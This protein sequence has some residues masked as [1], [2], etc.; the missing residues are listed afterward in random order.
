VLAPQLDRP[1]GAPELTT[2]ALLGELRIG[3][4]ILRLR[5][6]VPDLPTA[7]RAAVEAL[8]DTLSHHFAARRRSVPPA[9]SGLR[10]R[11][12]AAMAE[13]AAAMPAPGAQTAWLMLAGVQRSLFGTTEWLGGAEAADA[14]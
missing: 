2:E 13:A 6:T 8:L 3:L 4:N 12:M 11:G 14:R 1:A 10:E 7:A 5:D 9:L